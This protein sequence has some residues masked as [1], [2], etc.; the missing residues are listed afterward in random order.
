[1]QKSRQQK[2]QRWWTLDR[3]VL[4]KINSL[5]TSAILFWQPTN[6]WQQLDIKWLGIKQDIPYS[7]LVKTSVYSSLHHC[8][9]NITC[10]Q[11]IGCYYLEHRNHYQVKEQHVY[12]PQILQEKQK[13]RHTPSMV[14][15][16]GW[17]I[18]EPFAIP[19]TLTVLAPTC[20]I[21]QV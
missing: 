5:T 8:S 11:G 13:E 9:P 14:A 16:F 12:F 20:G 3:C 15:I 19:P 4:L 21:Y 6:H 18:P 17:I 10:N 1:M 7:Y 2:S